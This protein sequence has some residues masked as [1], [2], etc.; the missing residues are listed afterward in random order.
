M[1][2]G[3]VDP[4]QKDYNY[5][6]DWECKD[7]KINNFTKRKDCFKCKKP[8]EECEVRGRGTRGFTVGVLCYDS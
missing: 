7:C 6:A 1:R 8:K 5:T 3:L 2:P 4:M